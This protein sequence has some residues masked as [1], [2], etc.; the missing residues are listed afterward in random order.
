MGSQNK[1]AQLVKAKLIK[2]TL[3]YLMVLELVPSYRS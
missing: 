1:M 3:A 2:V